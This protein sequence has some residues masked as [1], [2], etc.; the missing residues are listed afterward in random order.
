MSSACSNAGLKMLMPLFDRFVNDRLLDY[1]SHSLTSAYP[2]HESSCS[3]HAPTVFPKYGSLPH[4]SQDCW[5]ATC[6]LKFDIL[7]K[8]SCLN[9]FTMFTLITSSWRLCTD[10]SKWHCIGN[11][12]ILSSNFEG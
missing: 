7:S 6:L 2:R 4:S 3:R 12:L 8:I 9:S 1:C 11:R 5:Q 10:S